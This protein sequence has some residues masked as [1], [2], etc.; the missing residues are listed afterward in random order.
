MTTKIDQKIV[1]ASVDTGAVTEPLTVEVPEETW[2]PGDRP[3]SM[4]GMTY[5]V[6]APGA[7]EE[8]IYVTITDVE[9]PFGARPY[10]MFIMSR[11][12]DSFQWITLCTRLV[13]A[14]FR[15]QV[16]APVYNPFMVNEFQQIF[17]PGKQFWSVAYKG[18]YMQSVVQE[19]G[20]I[21]QDHLYRLGL[22][23]APAYRKASTPPQA[24]ETAPVD[25]AP[26]PALAAP[27]TQGKAMIDPT[28][29]L[30]GS[31]CPECHDPGMVLMDGCPT[32]LVCGYSKC[33]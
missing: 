25:A 11:A 5:K 2:I 29:P 21:L 14:I 9:T 16:G 33:G 18:R 17:D 1:S 30:P 31:A 27:E 32:C 4:P 24:P 20:C 8:A 3:H 7:Y 6:S 19:I 13:S 26:I 28:G 12:Q 15:Q 10:E 23:D 22:L